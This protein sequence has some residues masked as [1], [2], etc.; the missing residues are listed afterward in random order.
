[1]INS[2]ERIT[3]PRVGGGAI[4]WPD[5]L[6][7]A[8]ERLRSAGERTAVIV[9][10]RASNEEAYLAQR[11]VR[12]ALGSADVTSTDPLPLA[13]LAALSAPGSRS[14]PRRSRR[15]SRCC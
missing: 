15:P 5:A 3:E 2:E 9:G 8:A 14:R 12:S 7:A 6:A 1:M 4:E 13:Q 11:I 10:G